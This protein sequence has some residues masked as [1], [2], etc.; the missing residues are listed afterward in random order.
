MQVCDPLVRVHH[1]DFGAILVD[2]LDIRFDLRSFVFRQA[3]D[4][5]VKVAQ[6]I[7]EI[8]A[9]LLIAN[10]IY[11]GMDEENLRRGSNLGLIS[12][13]INYALT[14]DIPFNMVGEV[15]K[16]RMQKKRESPVLGPYKAILADGDK[17]SRLK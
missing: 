1:G 11:F 4:L 17:P 12:C 14:G 15:P 9:K 2:L 3:R 5:V 16:Y 7:V 8:N 6:A 13:R 10:R